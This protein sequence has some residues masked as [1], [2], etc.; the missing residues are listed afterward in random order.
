M[1]L[2]RRLAF[3][4]AFVLALSGSDRAPAESVGT[5]ADVS[6]SFSAE[7]RA[8]FN[9]A[10]ADRVVAIASAPDPTSL[11]RALPARPGLDVFVRPLG[12]ASFADTNSFDVHLTS[13]PGVKAPRDGEPAQSTI[14]RIRAVKRRRQLLAENITRARTFAQA[15]TSWS[16]PPQRGTDVLGCVLAAS[17]LLDGPAR[18]I[19][20]LSDLEATTPPED[21]GLRLDAI[22]VVVVQV[23]VEVA[24]CSALRAEWTDRLR[25]LG[26][27]D[28]VFQRPEQIDALM[29]QLG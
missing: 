16:P 14:N 2:D 27:S 19:W 21:G 6:R 20:V 23:C 18:T 25:A 5:C 26:A 9:R 3:S 28:V 10:L 17:A 1:N 8:E 12:R 13:L 15:L 22:R 7:L 29:T 24:R 4:L 11:L